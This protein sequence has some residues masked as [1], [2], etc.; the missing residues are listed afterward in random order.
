[1]Y[2]M[3]NYLLYGA[4][5]EILGGD[6][7]KNSFSSTQSSHLES[8]ACGMSSMLGDGALIT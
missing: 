2:W 4:F 8:H 7:E 1:M 5:I 6:L 3:V